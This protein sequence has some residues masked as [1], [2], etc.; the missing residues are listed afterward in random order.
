MKCQQSNIDEMTNSGRTLIINKDSR[1]NFKNLNKT[2]TS[3]GKIC[4][5][6]KQRIIRFKFFIDEFYQT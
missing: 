6:K 5:L 1:R 4:N 2:M 3:T